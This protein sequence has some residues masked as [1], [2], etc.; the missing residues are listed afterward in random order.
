M[1]YYQVPNGTTLGTANLVYDV[2]MG[3]SNGIFI[4]YIEFTNAVATASNPIYDTCVTEN[5]GDP[6]TLCSVS[7]LTDQ[8]YI[9]AGGLRREDATITAS[10]TSVNDVM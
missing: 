7:Q 2:D 5:N 1:G 6:Q 3:T 8:M 10:M 4:Y 9:Y